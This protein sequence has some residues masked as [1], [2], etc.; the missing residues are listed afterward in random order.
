MKKLKVIMTMMLS[1]IVSISFSQTACITINT[2]AKTLVSGEAF[3]KI[4]DLDFVNNSSENKFGGTFLFS[5]TSNQ[6]ISGT[7]ES[8][9]SILEIN[10]INGLTLENNVIITNEL[11]LSQSVIDIQDYDLILSAN[12]V[13][14]GTFSSGN[15]INAAGTGSV[16]RNI[17]TIGTYLFPVGDLTSG[18]DYTPVE[19][20]FLQV[21]PIK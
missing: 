14:S 5:G 11:I 17:N 21:Q 10:N 9:F 12:A 16:I 8:E 19:L 20:D 15:M 13:I 2:N 6:K 18:A 3:I 4:N 1:I 7:V